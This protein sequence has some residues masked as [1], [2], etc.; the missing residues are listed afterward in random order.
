MQ[1]SGTSFA[2]PVV[3]AAAATLIA[4]HP[5]WTPDQVK[6]ALM[7]TATP[8][9][10]VGKAL[11]VGEISVSAA[12]SYK[13]SRIPNP[14]AGLEQFVNT[15]ADGTATFDAAAWQAAALT[16][17]AW[18]AVAWSDAAWSDAAWSSVAWS[19][20]AWASVAWASVAWG[21]VAW[22]DAA[23][24]DAA[25]SDVAW[26]DNAGDPAI[27]DAADATPSE[28]DAALAALG[29]VDDSCDPTISICSATSTLGGLLP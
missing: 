13:G 5:N 14:N 27:G 29:I 6:G 21:S 7:L 28:Q 15:A 3:S 24:S 20:A 11:G 25:W 18:N 23:W 4:Q 1:L 19:D 22:S 17:K 9:P 12:R 8:L 10:S 2:A 16:N 26:A